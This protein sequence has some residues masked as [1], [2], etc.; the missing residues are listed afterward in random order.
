[1]EHIGTQNIGKTARVEWRTYLNY[2][3]LDGRAIVEL[4]S[5]TERVSQTLLDSSSLVLARFKVTINVEPELARSSVYHRLS[6]HFSFR[7]QSSKLPEESEPRFDAAPIELFSLDQPKVDRTVS[8]LIIILL[9]I[10]LRAIETNASSN[11]YT[12]RAHITHAPSFSQIF[13]QF[14]SEP[15]ERILRDTKNEPFVPQDGP[16]RNGSLI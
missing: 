2:L 10:S 13:S 8:P 3:S 11:V 14:L 9:A 16:S 6:P 15:V 1:M 4:A 12:F 7:S 5:T